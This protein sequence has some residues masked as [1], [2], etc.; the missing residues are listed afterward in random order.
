MISASP[1]PRVSRAGAGSMRFGI[2]VQDFP[3]AV[4]NHADGAAA[5]RKHDDLAASSSRPL[6]AGNPSSARNETRGSSRSRSVTTPSTAVSARATSDT[7]S[8]SWNDLAH[9]VE[10]QRIFLLHPDRS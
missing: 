7:C 6:P 9:A 2:D 4:G 8:G 3:R 1:A 5:H 10:R